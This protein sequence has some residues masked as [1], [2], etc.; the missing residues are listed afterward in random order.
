MGVFSIAINAIDETSGGESATSLRQ[1]RG[2]ALGDGQRI[3]VR[4]DAD[5][6]VPRVPGKDEL[7]LQA[8]AHDDETHAA[9]V[10]IAAPAEQ[11]EADSAGS[12]AHLPPAVLPCSV[13]ILP[14]G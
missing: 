8:I 11:L 6:D 9:Q 4:L 12:P 13:N 10:E 3:A 14:R 1:G 7:E 5:G 2:G